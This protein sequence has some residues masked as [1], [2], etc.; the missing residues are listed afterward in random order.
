M[1]TFII[2]LT[3]FTCLT[4]AAADAFS[5]N[6]STAMIASSKTGKPVLI[7][8]TADWCRYCRMMEDS[9][10]K[11]EAVT[12]ALSR[13]ISVSIDYDR[14]GELAKQYKVRGIPAY[15]IVD[16]D[17][18]LAANS[19]GSQD[20]SAFKVFL[21]SG[22]ASTKS[23]EFRK[24]QQGKKEKWILE[25]L[26]SNDTD[27]IERAL[28]DLFADTA[29]KSERIRKSAHEQLEKL[30]KTRPQLLAKGLEHSK[31]ATRIHVYN[32]LRPLAAK[33]LQYDPW[34]TEE[35]R[36]TAAKAIANSLAP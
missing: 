25:T 2:I 10:L 14:N 6:L 12:N 5:T 17:G 3:L 30:A 35:N 32:L 22:Y 33:D 19:S 11:D 23:L 29:D 28:R 13:Y 27:R 20:P 4:N 9:T 36:T 34:E 26:T 21:M 1:K 16:A 24:E 18:D 7:E 31:L 8:F 15:V